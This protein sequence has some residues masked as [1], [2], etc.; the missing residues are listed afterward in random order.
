[1]VLRARQWGPPEGEVI[2]CLHGVTQHGAV[3]APLAHALA[4]HGRRVIAVD[5]R[6]HGAS[7]A[8][9]PWDAGTHVAD[10]VHTLDALGVRRATWIGHSFGGRLAATLAVA[11]PGLAERLVLLDPGLHVSPARAARGAEMDG[12]DWSFETP[13]GAVNAIL[14][15]GSVTSVPREVVA[16]YVRDA[17]RPGP[18]G[19]HRF[20]YSRGA[21]AVAWSEM[22]RP[23]PAIAAVPTL[24]VRPETPLTDGSA[25]DFRYRGELGRL[26]TFVIVPHGHNVLWESPAETRA[27]IEAFLEPPR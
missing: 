5:L 20:Q 11:H 16:A 10:L 4:E 15:S 8:E 3:F 17:V 13:E 24:L 9:P 26:L 25:D 2:V 18:D 14:S 7:P 23:A 12:Y 6:G 27:A 21:A 22:A 1:M 19:L